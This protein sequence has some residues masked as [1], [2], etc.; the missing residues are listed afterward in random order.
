YTRPMLDLLLVRAAGQGYTPD[1]ALCPDDTGGGR[2]HPWMCL[3]I[4]LGFRLDATSAAVKVGDTVSDIEEGL[5]A[6][7]WAVGVSATGNE[8]GLSAADWDAL[9]APERRQ[10]SCRAAEK[11]QAAGAHYV[12]ESVARLEPVLEEIDDRLS[13]GERP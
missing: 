5:N 12:I 13:A 11:L 2:P 1:A 6:G 7:M 3:Q 8:V 9:P 10:L 4:A